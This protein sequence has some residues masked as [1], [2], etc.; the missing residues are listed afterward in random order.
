MYKSAIAAAAAL[1]AAQFAA[2]PAQASGRDPLVIPAF[3]TAPPA[4]SAR[5]AP[6]QPPR[7]AAPVVAPQ[8]VQHAAAPSRGQYGG[9]F[10]EM[11]MTGRD[12]T[13]SR[14]AIY[15]APQMQQRVRPQAVAPAPAPR[16]E[17]VRAA[18]PRAPQMQ[19]NLAMPDMRP[20]RLVDPRYMKQEV[21]Y[22]SPHKPGTIV[23]DTPNRFLYLVL[24]NGRA[25]RYGIGVGRPGFEWAGRKSVTRKAEWPDW[26]PPPEMLKR[27]PDL[28]RFMAGG[29]DNPMGARA[30]YLG[31]SLYRIHGTNEPETI[32]QNVSS[33][34]IRM[35][36]DDVIDLYGRVR[37]GTAVIVI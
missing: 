35:M 11:L 9:G 30:L 6:A 19:A 23:V 7:A 25:L 1:S 12:P 15:H 26:R 2:L 36:N 4:Q 3:E 17:P 13:P 31:S 28:P 21:D 29:P 5:R 37:V 22:R 16:R 24:G 20:Q 18:A 34:C 8:R 27:R 33:G 14:G 32:G 10:I